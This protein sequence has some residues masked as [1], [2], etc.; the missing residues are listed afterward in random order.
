MPSSRRL[1]ARPSLEQLRKEAKDLL[2]DART[3]EAGA[4]A[5]IAAI[6]RGTPDAIILAQAQ[7]AL[8]REYGFPSWPALVH[9]VEAATGSYVRRPLIRPIELSPGRRWQLTDGSSAA[10]DDVYAMF[11][12]ARDG[13]I[14]TVKRLVAQARA[15]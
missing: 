6:T 7:L 9:H 1:P 4:V 3:G 12:A 8:A 11:V 10:T 13:D 5:R 14:A 2:R 15:F